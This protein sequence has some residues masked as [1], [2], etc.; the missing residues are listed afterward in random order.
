MKVRPF[1]QSGMD[2]LTEWFIDQTW[3]QVYSEQSA[4]KKAEIFQHL[5]TQKLDEIFPVKTRRISSDD[6]P[7]QMDRQ[8]KRIYKKERKSE[9]MEEN[10]Q[11]F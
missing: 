9:K 6:Q 11:N 10:G 8:K 4:H 2:Q 1:P 3:D 5:L 7:K